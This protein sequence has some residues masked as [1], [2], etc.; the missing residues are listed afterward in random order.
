MSKSRLTL[1]ER[2]V[3]RLISLGCTVGEA[4]RILRIS[5]NTVDNHKWQAMAKL[6]VNKTALL[7]RVAIRSRIT[8]LRDS[9]NAMEKRRC[10]RKDDG[11]N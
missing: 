10:G 9:L 6:G 11:W 4:A 7:T 2:E 1:R 3:V 8:S 5:R